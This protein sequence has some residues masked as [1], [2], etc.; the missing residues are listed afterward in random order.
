MVIRVEDYDFKGAA[1]AKETFQNTFNYTAEYGENTIVLTQVGTF[2]EMYGLLRLG[3]MEGEDVI[4][5]SNIESFAEICGLEIGFKETEVRNLK[6][7]VIYKLAIAGFPLV[8]IEKKIKKLNDNGFTIIQIDQKE[9][10]PGSERIVVGIYSPGTTLTDLDRYDSS[11]S[12]NTVCCWIEASKSRN[13]ITVGMSS[14]NICTGKSTIHEYNTQYKQLPTTYDEMQRFLTETRP[15]E[16]ILISPFDDSTI[17]SIIAY[18]YPNAKI[19][20]KISDKSDKA[21]N[22]EK[23]SY[24]SELLKRYYDFDNFSVFRQKFRDT[25]IATQ[26]FCYLLDFIYEHNPNLLKKISDPKFEELNNRV[27]LSN[28]TL[29]QLNI[30][31]DGLHKG[32]YSSLIKMLNECVTV[33]GKRAFEEMFLNPISN[34]EKLNKEYDMIE[35]VICLNQNHQSKVISTL[36]KINDIEKFL[37]TLSLGKIKP[38]NIYTIYTSLKHIQILYELIQDEN[39]K[40]YLEEKCGKFNT[41]SLADI[42]SYI[43]FTFN[44]DEC[45]ILDKCIN[46]DEHVLINPNVDEEY[47]LILKTKME[48]KDKL[49]ACCE[50]FND[51]SSKFENKKTKVNYVKI[52]YTEK[53]AVRLLST[54]AKTKIIQKA[55]DQYEHG[56]V[57]LSYLSSYDEKEYTFIFNLEGIEYIKQ[58]GTNNAIKSS[59]IDEYAK[60]M[61]ELK[62]EFEEKQ[63]EVYLMCVEH[64]EIYSKF[65]MFLSEYVSSIDLLYCKAN[66]AIKYNHARPIIRENENKPG[67][68]YMEVK[69]LRHPIIECINTNEIYVP[70]DVSLNSSVNSSVN[71]KQNGP[72][73]ITIFGVNAVGKSSYLRA[74][75]CMT[76]MIQVGMFSSFTECTYYPY[77]FIHT[78]FHNNDSLFQGLSTF[79]VEMLQI[80]RIYSVNDNALILADEICTGTESISAKCIFVALVEQLAKRGASYVFATH[81][82]EIIE[83]DEIQD[84]ISSNKLAIKHMAVTYDREQSKLIYHRKI[85][86]G[87]GDSIYGLEVCQSLN[88]PTEFLEEANRLRIKYN[89][90]CEGILS[91]STSR[92]NSEVIMGICEKCGI[93][94]S[95]ESH[96]IYKQSESDENGFIRTPG[97]RVFH[98]NVK[99]NI[100]S[101]CNTCHKLEHSKSS[102]ATIISDITDDTQTTKINSNESTS[103]KFE[104]SK[105]IKP[106]TSS[107][108]K[109]ENTKL[110]KTDSNSSKSIVKK[111]RFD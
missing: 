105:I 59:D 13:T 14:L 42:I 55:M 40:N 52:D 9:Q 80:N 60:N 19:T 88:M 107:T 7:G 32:K 23:Q 25:T 100:M 15:S 11:I 27:V 91:L 57:E 89:P 74:I 66:V 68:S 63:N 71:S 69:N 5:G 30:I 99:S 70:N 12:N 110:T 17:S 61:S 26:A 94:M 79:I 6:T 43:E 44:L 86:D 8:K 39:I 10:G 87:S 108:S 98:K 97:G 36:R 77:K 35:N 90:K 56:E 33:M 81:L 2:Y 93:K 111:S 83:Y 95:E 21:K 31:D 20:H 18:V 82:H 1:V 64:I 34:V 45:R 102:N 16:L 92:Y 48:S 58:T 78:K 84:L 101:V 85:R 106:V 54:N 53:Y 50:F 62:N 73:G 38:K 67:S 51:V 41:S 22:S 3:L 47:D 72:S 76:L 96:H 109:T 37:R 49:D 75:G 28:S 24:Q 104:P 29:K 103:S 46:F 4:I 65:L